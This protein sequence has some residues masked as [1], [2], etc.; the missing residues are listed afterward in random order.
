MTFATRRFLHL[1]N[2]KDLPEDLIVTEYLPSD[3]NEDG[4]SINN[5]AMQY[6]ES[7]MVYQDWSK[8]E[9]KTCFTIS[10][11]MHGNLIG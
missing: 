1:V 4:N 11:C 9:G 2:E 3:K 10:Y 8:K 7:L 6:Q 5:T